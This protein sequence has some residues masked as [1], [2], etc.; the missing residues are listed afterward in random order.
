MDNGFDYMFWDNT[1]NGNPSLS[2]IN[3]FDITVWITG[4]EKYG[5][6]KGGKIALI[7]IARCNPRSPG[8]PDPVI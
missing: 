8:G 6:I 3:Q 1:A 4:D 5:V 7:R 2:L